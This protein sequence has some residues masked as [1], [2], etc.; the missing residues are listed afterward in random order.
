MQNREPSKDDFHT[1]KTGLMTFIDHSQWDNNIQAQNFYFKI[2]V[3]LGLGL[4]CKIKTQC[5]FDGCLCACAC[6]CG[7]S[8]AR[9]DHVMH[10]GPVVF[11]KLQQ[12]LHPFPCGFEVVELRILRRW[13]K[14]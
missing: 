10:A 4:S 11:L 9:R 13:C 1:G 3:M 6:A 7:G 12:E 8:P 14:G 5:L 2:Y